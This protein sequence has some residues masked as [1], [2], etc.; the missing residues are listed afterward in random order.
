MT[1][2]RAIVREDGLT[3]TTRSYFL[4]I[5]KDAWLTEHPD[6][7]GDI[8]IDVGVTFERIDNPAELYALVLGAIRTSGT[9]AAAPPVTP[10]QSA[11]T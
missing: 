1:S 3:R 9:I 6:G 11:T 7:I 4:D 10:A 5:A 2:T 8:G